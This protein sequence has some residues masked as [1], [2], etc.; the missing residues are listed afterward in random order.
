MAPAAI[1]PRPD[2]QDYD[3]ILAAKAAQVN[4]NGGALKNGNV[5]GADVKVN[6]DY[7]GNYEFAPIEEADV[8][9]AMIKR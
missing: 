9:R 3:K 2:V 5:N 6:E 4:I 1:A 8:S 7:E